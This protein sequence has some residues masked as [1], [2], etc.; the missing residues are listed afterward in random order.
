MATDAK[1]FC[2]NAAI[3]LATNN[4]LSAVDALVTGLL[5]Q[6]RG[7]RLT[8]IR[9]LIT[10]LVEHDYALLPGIIADLNRLQSKGA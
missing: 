6:S 4:P 5:S 1:A 8:S 7:A 2:F 9:L 10:A 3:F